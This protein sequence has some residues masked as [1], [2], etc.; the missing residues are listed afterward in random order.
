M[1]DT[2]TIPTTA[3]TNGTAATDSTAHTPR[4]D[5]TTPAE[6]VWM[7]RINPL[8]RTP[9]ADETLARL[10][11]RLAHAEHTTTALAADC[12]DQLYTRIGGTQGEERAR[13]VALRRAV[14]NGRPPTLPAGPPP[15]PALPLWHTAREHLAQLRQEVRDAHDAAIARER[16]HLAALLADEDLRRSLALLAPEVDNAAERYRQAAAPA[17]EP[18]ARLRKSERGLLQYVTRAMVRTS[19]LSRLT[20]VALAVP[21]DHG[22]HPGEATCTGAVSHLSLDRVMAGYVAA[23]LPGAPSRLPVPDGWVQRPPTAELD[24]D[25]GRY[26]FLA[27]TADGG[28]R[29]LAAPPSRPLHLLLTLTDM[30]PRP[31]AD[32]AAE[33]ARALDLAIPDAVRAV[34]D[35]VRVGILC[36]ATGPEDWH[37]DPL[38]PPEGPTTPE[39][40]AHLAT[41]REELPSLARASAAQRAAALPGIR[42]AAAELSRAAARPA[43]LLVE[44]DS[45]AP[46][47]AL[48]TRAWRRRLDDLGHVVEF[49]SLFD[50]MHDVRQ[51]LTAAFTDRF[52][53]GASIPLWQHA[54]ALVREVYHRETRYRV[55]GEQGLGPADGTLE[56]LR[57]LRRHARD[58]LAADLAGRDPA[59]EEA[60]WNP[61]ELSALAD[62]LPEPLRRDP[63]SYGVLI[64][65]AGDRL[66]VNDAYAGHGMLYGRFLA[67][68]TRAGGTAARRLA[69]RLTARYGHDGAAV[70]EDLGLHRL[71]VNAHP[72]VL[73]DGLHAQDWYGLRLAHDPTTGRL[74]I[75]RPDGRELRTVTL[76]AG[77][78]ELYPAPLRIATWLL[79]G[80]RLIGDPAMTRH[81]PADGDPTATRPCPRLVAGDVVLSRR[82]WYPGEDFGAALAAGPGDTDRL[83]ALTAWR[84]RHGVPPELVFKTAADPTRRAAAQDRRR[85]KPQYADL[86][87]ALMTRVLP[88][89]L[90]RGGTGYAEEALPGVGASAHAF[91]WVVEISRASGGRFTYM[92]EETP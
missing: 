3:A 83:L 40:R 82:R 42:H 1:T 22:T 78:P 87:S 75:E 29:R 59:A 79:S 43:T 66:V 55:H 14:H 62:G 19:P 18:P 9:L 37:T 54:D 58:T 32:V 44:E 20:A 47:V 39:V 50:R 48:T 92:A 13:L 15:V 35:A 63:L 27:P 56:T 80:G 86:R 89:L 70:A 53:T 5:T 88:R 28:V 21:G 85:R 71:N 74:R 69:D 67:A 77:F 73:P 7:L 64:Q 16:R 81:R 68:D 52:G 60:G 12:S 46:P 24:P 51:L 49:Q 57:T 6:P 65:P 31:I 41:V 61:S 36:T 38:T 33:A 11:T 23:G 8:R 4:P 90:E 26:T 2:P 76:G 45:T 10:V 72:P 91:E 17:G 30:G 34:T 84:A 25:T